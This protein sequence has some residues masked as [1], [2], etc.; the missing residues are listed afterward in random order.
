MA[1]RRPYVYMCGV[2]KDLCTGTATPMN[3]GM[4]QGNKTHTSPESAFSCMRKSLLVQGW[5]QLGSREFQPPGGGPIRILTKKTRF[6][7][8]MR[9]GKEGTR[10][11]PI[12]GGGICF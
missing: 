6:G 11:Q 10:N 12:R 1:T 5:T 3:H 8:R 4:G 7:G 2:E 9:N